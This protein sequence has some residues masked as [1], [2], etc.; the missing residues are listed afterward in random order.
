MYI[1]FLLYELRMDVL[2]LDVFAL[3]LKRNLG[4]RHRAGTAHSSWVQTSDAALQK[5]VESI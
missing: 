3:N 1:I 5:W 2:Y 4:W